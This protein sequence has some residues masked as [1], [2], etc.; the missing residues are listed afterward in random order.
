MLFV[1]DVTFISKNSLTK[2]IEVTGYNVYR[3]GVKLTEE[4]IA[5]TTFVDK[6]VD[7]SSSYCY[8]VTAIYADGES[9]KSNDAV[10]DRSQ[11]SIA[12]VNADDNIRIYT[13]Q[14]AVVVEGAAGCEINVNTAE[15]KTIRALVGESRNVISL[16][17]GLY[18][19]KAGATTAKVVVK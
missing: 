6:T 9:V 19:V 18:I 12:D 13:I 5:E 16:S 15:G 17:S 7:A 1:D 10:V 11:S 3:D 8:N 14:G 4:P 2:T